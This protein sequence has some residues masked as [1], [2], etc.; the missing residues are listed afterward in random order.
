[1][2]T[3]ITYFCEVKLGNRAN[4]SPIMATWHVNNLVSF[5]RFLD[6]KHPGWTYFNVKDKHSRVT[7][8]SFTRHHRPT[9]KKI[10]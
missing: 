7:L 10:V 6:R 1:M 4:G 3:T 5:A 9:T 8:A 2:K